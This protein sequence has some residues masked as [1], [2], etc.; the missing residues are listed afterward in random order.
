MPAD[1]HPKLRRFLS[2]VLIPIR[3]DH[4]VAHDSSG[5][6][7]EKAMEQWVLS[8]HIRDRRSPQIAR[9]AQ[10][11]QRRSLDGLQKHLRTIAPMRGPFSFELGYNIPPDYRLLLQ[12]IQLSVKEG[13]QLIPLSDSGSGTQSMAVFAL[14]AYLADLENTNYILGLEEPEQNLHPQ[15]Q[16]QLMLNLSKLGL[17]VVFTTHSPTI[18]DTLDHEQ[19]VLC[20]RHKSARRELEVKITQIS[21]TFF[22][23]HDLNRDSYYKFHRRKNSQFL[24]ANFVVVTESPIDSNVIEQLLREADVSIEE[25][26]MTIFSVDGIP[27]LP[28]MFHL[29]RAL[30]IPAAFVVD[31]D[32]FVP[33]SNNNERK[34]SLNSKGYPT[35]SPVLK[36]KSLL[37]LLF[38]NQKERTALLDALVN[39]HT[40]AM[41]ILQSANFFCFQYSLEIDLVATPTARERLYDMTGL[42][43]DERTEEKLLSKKDALKDQ[44]YLL[45]AFT[46]VSTG[47]LPRSYRKLRSQL[48]IMAKEARPT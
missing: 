3:R 34:K 18:V 23:D 25:I 42:V 44:A 2:F 46:G 43:G 31:K 47:K 41:N 26:G 33:Y 22:S 9:V 36:S 45:Q 27:S 10:D 14:Y 6:L 48:P 24:F 15:A 21:S 30:Q 16:Q 8:N 7:L 11:L 1:F 12:N 13:G 32:F 5:G 39:H 28:H 37:P 35:Y 20:R 38:P 29:L 17:Q 19:V 4:E 40:N